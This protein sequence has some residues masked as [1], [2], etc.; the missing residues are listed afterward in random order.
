MSQWRVH[1]IRNFFGQLIC[2][3][4][5]IFLFGLFK[6][7]LFFVEC[8]VSFTSM[9]FFARINSHSSSLFYSLLVGKKLLLGVLFHD[10]LFS[11]LLL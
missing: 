4:E 2:S 11:F 9:L 3:F 8:F 1:N 6:L 10:V 7:F 5:L